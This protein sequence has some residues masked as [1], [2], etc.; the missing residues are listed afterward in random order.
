MS[1]GIKVGASVSRERSVDPPADAL[2]RR[3]CLEMHIGEAFSFGNAVRPLHNG[4]GIFPPML[5]AIRE[6]RNSINLLSYIYRKGDI[7]ERFCQALC[8]RARA[9]VTVRVLVDAI[10]AA[11]MRSDHAERMREAGVDMRRF[12]KPHR[13]PFKADKRTHRKALICDNSVGFTGGMGIGRRW[14]GDARDPSEWREMHFEFRG[15]CV[16]A[17]NGSFWD[18]WIE[19]CPEARPDFSA[20]FEVEERPG[21]AAV[22]LIH[23]DSGRSDQ[24]ARVLMQTLFGLARKRIDI[25]SAYLSPDKD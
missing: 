4:R 10:G 22:Q 11:E 13:F 6:A 1:Q 23:L 7:A 5:Q 14:E 2:S 3:H 25:V 21:E 12:R 9:G 8:E 18:N 16:F 19:A 20:N 15:P 17:L 24:T